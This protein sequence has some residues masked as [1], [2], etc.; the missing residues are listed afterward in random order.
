[1][2]LNSKL[3]MVVRS[4]VKSIFHCFNKFIGEII[5]IRLFLKGFELTPTMNNV[6]NKFSCKFYVNLVLV[7]EDERRYFKQQEIILWR[8]DLK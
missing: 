4:K 6:N 7:D 5:P 8:K 1:M 2:W 3:W